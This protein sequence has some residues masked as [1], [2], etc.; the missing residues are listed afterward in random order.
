MAA[1]NRFVYAFLIVVVPPRLINAVGLV[2]SC[3]LLP[4]P[5]LFTMRHGA[6][7]IKRKRNNRNHGRAKLR[8]K[9][10][11]IKESSG[12]PPLSG[13]CEDQRHNH[14]RRPETPLPDSVCNFCLNTGMYKAPLIRGGPGLCFYCDCP[15]GTQILSEMLSTIQLI[16]AIDGR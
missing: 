4:A 10:R 5:R 16:R 9:T 1:R 15:Y 7:A 11:R 8:K 12:V 14:I 2:D 3:R 13:A 6:R